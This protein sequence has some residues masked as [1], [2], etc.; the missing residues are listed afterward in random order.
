MSAMRKRSDVVAL[1]NALGGLPVFG[2]L[3]G[4]PADLA[5]IR[6]GDIV[7]SLDGCATP[8]WDM[9]LAVRER[10]GTVIALKLFRDGAE[11]DVRVDL[12]AGSTPPPADIASVLGLADEGS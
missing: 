4:S 1:A 11:L 8:S 5:G 6:Y 10:S 2:C 3:A 12:R 9:Y 7:M